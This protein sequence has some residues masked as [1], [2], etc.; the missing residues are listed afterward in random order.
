MK[1]YN[2]VILLIF[3]LALF[4]RVYDLSNL[5]TGLH[6]DEASIGY[7]AYS[8]LKTARD[9]NG[10]FLPLVIDQFGD[11][12]PAGYHYLAIPFVATLGL[13]EQAVR[14]PGA[15]FGALTIFVFYLLILELFQNK[16]VAM[17]GSFLLTIT[18]WHI[19]ISRATSESIVAA[20]FII[21]GTYLFLKGIKKQKI[22][23]LLFSFIFLSYFTS[24]LFYHAARFFVPAF[25]IVF[26]PILFTIFKVERQKKIHILIF[27]SVLVVS[28]ILLMIL[29]RGASRPINISILNIPGG[30]KL[31]YQQIAEDGKQNPLITR[32]FHNKLHFYSRLFEESFSKHISLDFLFVNNGLPIRYRMPWT[33]NLYMV[34]LPFLVFGFATLLIDGV[35]SKKL[36]YFIPLTWLILGIIPAALTYEDVPNVQRSSLMLPALIIIIIYGAYEVFNLA[37]NRKLKLII[38][39]VSA[40]F[41]LQNFLYFFH[42]YFKHGKADEPWHRSAAVKELIFALADIEKQGKR[43]FITTQGNNNLIHYLFYNKFDPATFQ[44]LGSPSEKNGLEFQNLVYTYSSCPLEGDPTK[45]DLVKEDVVY[46][47]QSI[48][49]K[50]PKNTKTLKTIYHPDGTPAFDILTLESFN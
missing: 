14:L 44:K 31:I 41:L 46:V 23:L 20:F 47:N 12:R 3:L 26:I 38:F 17:A 9:Q 11:F 2:Y 50:V 8:L 33:G 36:L 40:I 39:S 18:P 25:L 27:A 13:N 19:N 35:R 16:K 15:I 10:H 30:D 37:R 5:P 42:N 21:L 6:G 29:G 32:I 28:L 4:L 45:N 24:F 49:K 48:C 1:F 43:I 34:F 7:N 22:S